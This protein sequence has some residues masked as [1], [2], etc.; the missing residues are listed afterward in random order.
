MEIKQE[1]LS[2]DVENSIGSLLG[3]RK[4][5]YRAGTYTSQKIVDIMGFNTVNIHC[6]IISG[7]KDNGKDT[8]ILYT[9]NLTERPGYMI[10]NI[11]TNVLYQNVTKDRIEY[12]EFHIKDEHGRPI[13]FNGDVLSFTLHLR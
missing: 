1:A 4:V 2:F 11:P 3:F 10:I 9:F 8:D 13:D 6:N 5:L 7:A 12:I